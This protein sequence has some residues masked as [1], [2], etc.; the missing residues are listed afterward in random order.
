M[1]HTSFPE[2][3]EIQCDLRSG[4]DLEYRDTLG[5][6]EFVE[7]HYLLSNLAGIGVA[8]LWNF[9]MNTHITWKT[10]LRTDW[11]LALDSMATIKGM[12]DDAS[13]WSPT[14]RNQRNQGQPLTRDSKMRLT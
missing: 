12:K 6:D 13:E 11:K 7:I 10:M 4:C 1:L 3:R 2:I 14:E 9:G 8:S 5:D